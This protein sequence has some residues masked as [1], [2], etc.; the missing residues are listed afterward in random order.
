MPKK[1]VLVIDDQEVFREFFQTTL[2]KL[3]L[4]VVTAI[5]GKAG[6]AKAREHKPDLVLVDLMLPDI[7]GFEVCH[8]LRKQSETS[9]TPIIFISA[10]HSEQHI[11]RAMEAGGNDYLTKP[12]SKEDIEKLLRYI[13]EQPQ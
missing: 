10:V 8:E 7:D 13:D 3:G 2:T 9:Q 6:L 1:K 5:T 12:L 11:E 4:E